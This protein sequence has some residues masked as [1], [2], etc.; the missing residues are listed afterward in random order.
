MSISEPAVHFCEVEKNYGRQQVLSGVDLTIHE[1]DYLGLV[2][3]NG[4]GK[5]TL[6]K[7]LLDFSRAGSGSIKIYSLP[8]TDYR[9]RERLAYLPEKFLAPYYLTGREFLEYTLRLYQVPRIEEEILAMA[10]V[11]DMDTNSLD[12]EARKYSKGMSQKLGLA[13]CLLS[14]R[15]LFVMD[16]PMSGLDPRARASLKRHLLELKSQGKTLFFST[17]LL[18]D[19]EALCDKVAILHEGQ[20]RFLGSPADCCARFETED[21]EQAY[22]KCVGDKLATSN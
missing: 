13:A 22:L 1:G 6:I 16:E 7:C 2:G 9:A 17:H 19:V 5:T 3:V 14:N 8:S 11:L 20:V 15:D 18:S 4:A 12:R 21:F 10:A